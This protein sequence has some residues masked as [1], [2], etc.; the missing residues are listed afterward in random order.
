MVKL[1]TLYRIPGDPGEFERHYEEI[2][3]PLLKKYPGL[4]GLETM[5]ISGA[6]PGDPRFSRMTEL[7]FDSRDAM[8]AAL[9]SPQGKAV[10][11]D[12]L[13][14]AGELVTIFFG[15]V[16]SYGQDGIV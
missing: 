11:R 15:D 3:I 7:L 5:R 4:R 12:L 2:H 6:S 14:F 8:D 1:V 9:A 13:S 10:T 16:T